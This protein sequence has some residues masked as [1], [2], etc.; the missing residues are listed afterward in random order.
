MNTKPFVRI[1]GLYDRGISYRNA[2]TWFS[3][4]FHPSPMGTEK[5][6]TCRVLINVRARRGSVANF[7]HAACYLL[8]RVGT[9]S[10]SLFLR[11]LRVGMRG[12]DSWG[13][14]SLRTGGRESGKAAVPRVARA[15]RSLFPPRPRVSQAL[16]PA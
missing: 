7:M 1:A 10:G 12:R 13:L 2:S 16:V 3:G 4:P 9:S 8:S 5:A 6:P 15:R 14:G 11:R